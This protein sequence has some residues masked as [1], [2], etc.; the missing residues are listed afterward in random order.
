MTFLVLIETYQNRLDQD[1]F[2]SELDSIPNQLTIQMELMKELADER[3]FN[4]R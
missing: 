2:R 1:I 4:G 3:I